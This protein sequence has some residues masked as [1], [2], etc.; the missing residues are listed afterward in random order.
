MPK[1]KTTPKKPRKWKRAEKVQL[2]LFAVITVAALVTGVQLMLFQI[3]RS[4]AL[5][6]VRP[7][8]VCMAHDRLHSHPVKVVLPDSRTYYSCSDESTEQ[9]RQHDSVR[10]AKDPISGV[11]VDKATALL[12]ASPHKDVFYFEN[13]E[14]L[15][16]FFPS[17]DYVRTR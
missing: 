8:Q 9:L 17:H 2:L 13:E 11:T 4:H 14:N 12:G 3:R 6:V 16:N 1:K 15:R 10:V 5:H 7:E